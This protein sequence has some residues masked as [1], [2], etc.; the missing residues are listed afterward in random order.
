MLPDFPRIKTRFR[1][2]INQYLQR[3]VRQ[4]PFLSEIR[5]ERHFEGDKIS[6]RTEDGETDVSDYKE[7]TGQLEIKKEEIIAKG[8]LAFIEK[9]R[10]VAE[11][12]KKQK[13]EYIFEKLNEITE[14]TGNK[15]DAKGQPLTFEHF[16]EGLRK[17]QIDF[18]ESDKPHLPTMVVSP[19]LGAKLREKLPQWEADPENKKRFDELI[20][21]KRKEWNDRESHRK[22][23]N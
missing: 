19:I 13:A 14:K 2:V 22:L 17:I 20:G 1:R 23:V 18:D 8:P 3:L 7:I 21:K 12:I 10:V 11:Q 16:I 5:E 9:T 15:V 4:E 6:C